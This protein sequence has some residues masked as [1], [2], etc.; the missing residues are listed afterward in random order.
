MN[1]IRVH[2]ACC[3]MNWSENVSL[4]VYYSCPWILGGTV[5]ESYFIHLLNGLTS[6]KKNS[7]IYIKKKS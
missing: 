7:V 3:Q 5:L 6:E 1:K 4:H 2:I